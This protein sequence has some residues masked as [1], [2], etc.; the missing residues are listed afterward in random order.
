MRMSILAIYYL[1]LDNPGVKLPLVNSPQI[2]PIPMTGI[3]G[4]LLTKMQSRVV[5]I[6]NGGTIGTS[7]VHIG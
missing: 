4:F 2:Y 7:H 6:I 1:Y 5:S 3:F